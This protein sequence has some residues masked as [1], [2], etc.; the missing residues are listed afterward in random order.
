[1]QK[2]RTQY[3][4]ELVWLLVVMTATVIIAALLFG[5]VFFSGTL[6]IHLHDTYFVMQ[7]WLLLM[8]IFLLLT[9]G[10]YF[11]REKQKSFVRPF[12]NG[13]LAIVGIALIVLLTFVIQNVSQFLTVGSTIHSPQSTLGIANNISN[14]TVSTFTQSPA[15]KIVS[16]FL[17]IVQ[18]TVLVLFSYF[19]FHWGAKQPTKHS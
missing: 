16:S 10:T 6:D 9:F 15:A 12:N 13:L 5:K 1:M 8:P 17:I 4:R 19:L 11:I 3:L 7:S 14:P 18:C 2:I